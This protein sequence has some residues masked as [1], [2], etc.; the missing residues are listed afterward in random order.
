[1]TIAQTD[2]Q[3]KGIIHEHSVYGAEAIMQALVRACKNH[4]YLKLEDLHKMLDSAYKHEV[5]YE[6]RK[7]Y[8]ER[9]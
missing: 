9:R 1:M 4:P 2:S 5:E 3:I 7:L 6:E 8:D